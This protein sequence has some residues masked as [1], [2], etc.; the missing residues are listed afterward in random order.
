MRYEAKE[1]KCQ[2]P[3]TTQK[4]SPVQPV[5]W[6][7]CIRHHDDDSINDGIDLEM[8]MQSIMIQAMMMMMQS[9]LKSDGN[10][11]WEFSWFWDGGF[12]RS[13]AVWSRGWRFDIFNFF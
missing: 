10:R 5:T 2:N 12:E 9:I 1:N 4:Q 13:I 8:V 11:F 6:G 3:K 7:G